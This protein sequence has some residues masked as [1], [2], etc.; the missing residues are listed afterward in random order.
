M[1]RRNLLSLSAGFFAPVVLGSCSSMGE[2]KKTGKAPPKS[3]INAKSF[4]ARRQEWKGEDWVYSVVEIGDRFLLVYHN[5][6]LGWAFPGG[7]VK[8]FDH[9]VKEEDNDDLI[10]A[11]TV[12]VHDQAMVP[13]MGGEAIVMSYGYVIDERR[14]KM[15]MVH[16]LNIFCLADNLP[17]PQ[18][19]L[20]DTREARWAALDDPELGRIL[21]MRLDEMKEAGEGKTLNLK[22]SF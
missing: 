15:K 8:P 5:D 1:T 18:A 3:K 19:N 6:E 12:Y 4:W 11:A 22:P 10:K 17:T 16:W 21:K 9:G 13:V 2:I 7:V 20:K 14:S